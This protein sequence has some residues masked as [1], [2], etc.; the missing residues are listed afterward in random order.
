MPPAGGAGPQPV[1]ARALV[2]HGL[3]IRMS[4][5]E[6]FQH[7]DRLRIGG[8]ERVVRARWLVG[9]NRRRGK[10][11]FYLVLYFSSMECVRGRVM[12]FGGCWCPVDRYEFARRSVPLACARQGPW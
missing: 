7:A 10:T 2:V 3:P 4:I 6:I 5:D 11:A 9:L 8:G 1:G 12:R